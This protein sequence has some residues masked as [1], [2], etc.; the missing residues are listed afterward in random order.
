MCDAAM[1]CALQRERLVSVVSVL[2]ELWRGRQSGAGEVRES[3]VSVWRRAVSGAGRDACVRGGSMPD[4]GADGVA[5]TGTNSVT[6]Q[7][8]DSV[9]DQGA[10]RGTDC[11]LQARAIPRWSGERPQRCAR[12]GL[13]G[14]CRRSVQRGIQRGELCG[15]R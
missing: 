14:M 8:A 10:D 11:C 15:V 3:A 4:A 12:R 9:P 7:G 1:R 2:A 5:H 6:E 13:R